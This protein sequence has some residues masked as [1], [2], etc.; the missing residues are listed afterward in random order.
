[1]LG[2]SALVNAVSRL[3]TSSSVFLSVILLLLIFVLINGITNSISSVISQLIIRN[4]FNRDAWPSY[5]CE[6]A[7]MRPDVVGV[8]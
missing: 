8:E 1:M 4:V 2:S 7:V 3:F 5:P 6:D